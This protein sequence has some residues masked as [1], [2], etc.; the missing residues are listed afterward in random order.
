LPMVVC[1]FISFATMTHKI[2][3]FVEYFRGYKC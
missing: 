1:L 2:I 3:A